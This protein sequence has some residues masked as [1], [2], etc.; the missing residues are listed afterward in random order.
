MEENCHVIQNTMSKM[1][2]VK[3]SIWHRYKPVNIEVNSYETKCFSHMT[4]YRHRNCTCKPIGKMKH[5]LEDK[6]T[7]PAAHLFLHQHIKV[8]NSE[9]KNWLKL[10]SKESSIA[11][12]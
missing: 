8:H 5:H 3:V 2:K 7:T 6:N 10:N 12:E 4:A 1:L 9:F 11:M